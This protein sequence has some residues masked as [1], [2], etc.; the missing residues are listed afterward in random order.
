[1]SKRFFD[2]F[3]VNKPVAV[4]T[5]STKLTDDTDSDD[6]VSCSLCSVEITVKCVDFVYETCDLGTLL[7]EP[8]LS[9]FEES[10]KLNLIKC[11]DFYTYY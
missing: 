8:A 3:N 4:A 2:I 6:P 7:T 1:M 11:L 9:M 10:I 5:Y